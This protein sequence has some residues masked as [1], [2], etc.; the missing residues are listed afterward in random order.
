DRRRLYHFPRSRRLEAQGRG[1]QGGGGNLNGGAVEASL[2][3]LYDAV[4]IARLE[5][6]LDSAH[7]SL[8]GRQP[9]P[10]SE[11]AWPRVVVVVQDRGSS[12]LGWAPR[13]ASG[14]GA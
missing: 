11:G 1:H 4:D 2:M 6:M 3:Q 7:A 14:S 12:L 9:G 10:C 13:S 8:S 5:A